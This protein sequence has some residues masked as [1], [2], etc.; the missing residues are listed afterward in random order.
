MGLGIAFEGFFSTIPTVTGTSP[1][2]SE[3]PIMQ[4]AVSMMIKSL[5]VS[6]KLSQTNAVRSKVPGRGREQRRKAILCLGYDQ[7]GYDS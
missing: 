6:L 1:G 7:T 4:E 2:E 5:T 3:P